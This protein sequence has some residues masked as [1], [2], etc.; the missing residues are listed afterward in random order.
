ME[1]K[2]DANHKKM[3]AMLDAHHENTMASLGTTEVT[4]FKATP[5]EMESLTEHEKIPT[6]DAVVMAVGGPRKRLRVR[7]LAA[8]RRQKRKERSRGNSGSR[9]KSAAACSK[10]PRHAKVAWRK[11]NLFTKIRIQASGESRKGLT[12]A[13][14][15]VPRRA[16]V[17]WRKRNTASVVQELQRGWMF[18]MRRWIGLKQKL[19][20]RKRITDLGGRLP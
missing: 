7:N 16:T 13:R 15:K 12:V 20:G 10:V 19:Q 1:A 9:R 8:E 18:G 2:P 3:M 11:R 6:E 14:K 17:A 4:D 5:E